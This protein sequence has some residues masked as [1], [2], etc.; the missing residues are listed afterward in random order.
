MMTIMYIKQAEQPRNSND[1]SR[2]TNLQANTNHVEGE[3]N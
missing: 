1:L 3:N 2:P